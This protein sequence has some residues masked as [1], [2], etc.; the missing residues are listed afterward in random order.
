MLC[1]SKI[2]GPL[3]QIIWNRDAAGSKNGT[4]IVGH[5]GDRFFRKHLGGR[6]FLIALR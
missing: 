4:V 2:G 3:Y 6:R 1:P 5:H